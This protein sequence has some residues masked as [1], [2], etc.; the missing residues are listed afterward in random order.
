MKLNRKDYNASIP[1]LAKAIMNLE[2]DVAQGKAL[3]TWIA[4]ADDSV[5]TGISLYPAGKTYVGIATNRP[6]EEVSI[7]DPSVFTWSKMQGSGVT[8]FEEFTNLELEAL[9]K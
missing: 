8:D 4:Y 7:A 6:V 2:S 1:E 9:L 3:Y 5:G